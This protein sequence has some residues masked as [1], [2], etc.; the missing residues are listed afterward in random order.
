MHGLTWRSF[1]R[2][3]EWR[4]ADEHDPGMVRTHA[5]RRAPR[6]DAHPAVPD[7]AVLLAHGRRGDGGGERA[8][9]RGHPPGGRTRT[10][11]SAGTRDRAARGAGLDAR[12]RPH[13][14]AALA[15]GRGA[16][17]RRRDGCGAA[18]GAR[19]GAG[20]AGAARAV[21]PD[22]VAAARGDRGHR[23][24]RPR[25]VGEPGVPRDDGP[26]LDG[27]RRR[28]RRGH[29]PP[30]AIQCGCGETS[31]QRGRPQRRSLDPP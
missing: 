14:A 16:A 20:G 22:P 24:A 17:D 18:R 8:A 27:G 19:E 23:R 25:G 2:R 13:R 6:A 1:A 29:P 30:Q 12:A 5:A 21:A 31:G 11:P 15:R 4:P 10:D 9:A 7:R 26:T 3:R 28:H